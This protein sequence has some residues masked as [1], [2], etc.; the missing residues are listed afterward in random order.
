MAVTTVP[1]FTPTGYA[2]FAAQA[3]PTTIALPA[4]TAPA[5]VIVSCLGPDPA[6]VVLGTAAAT[7]T[8]TASSGSTALTVA[9]ATGIV[10][11]Q[12]VVGTGLQPGTQVQ[13]IVGLVITLTLPTTAALAAAAVNF[14]TALTLS[15]GMA[16][17]PSVPLALAYGA[18]TFI[19][20]IAF[21][22]SRSVLNVAV[23]V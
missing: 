1:T 21:S 19:S 3:F 12:N 11:G 14:I 23:G 13:K 22:G 5:T 6:I 4:G 9:S 7:T 8:G 17:M 15:T 18:N 16:A 10:L 2:Q 20:A